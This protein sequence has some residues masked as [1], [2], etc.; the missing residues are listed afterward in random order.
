M[1][2]IR[3]ERVVI[4]SSDTEWQ[5][6]KELLPHCEPIRCSPYGEWCVASMDV[7]GKSVDV[8][9]VHGG[10]GKVSAA[11]SAQYVID[12]W[13]PRL[14]INLGA[15]GG[16]EGQVAKGEILLVT[17]TIIYD[18]IEQI[19]DYEPP[20]AHYTTSLDLSWLRQP[21]PLSVTESVMMSADKDLDKQEIPHLSATFGAIAG[22]W[23]SGAIAFVAHRNSTRCLILRGVSDVVGPD[24]G[25]AYGNMTLFREG[26]YA[27][28]N[29]LLSS[30]PAWIVASCDNA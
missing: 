24:G 6:T 11:A 14:L 1:D 29:T 19:G 30:L 8:P 5:I 2:K 10:W 25:E 17:S 28:M 22:D 16:F 4:I 21:Y 26:T 18:I 23:E 15:C 20:L 7:H 13:H 9:F 12:R 27:I 3:Y